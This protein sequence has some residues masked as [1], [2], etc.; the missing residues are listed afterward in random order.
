M[1]SSV[2]SSAAPRYLLL[3]D[4]NGTLLLRSDKR[5]RGI[6][7]AGK[8]GRKHLYGRLGTRSLVR[9]LSESGYFT[10]CVYTSMKRVNASGSLK[11]ILGDDSSLVPYLLDRHYCRVDPQGANVC[12]RLCSLGIVSSN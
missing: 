12:S 6:R 10:L 5:I 2:I 1:A 8:V 3:L 9:Q 7:S 11:A 4:L